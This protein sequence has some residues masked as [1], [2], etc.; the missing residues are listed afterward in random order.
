MPQPPETFDEPALR[1]WLDGLG[2]SAAESVVLAG[3][4]SPRR[5]RRLVRRDASVIVALYP[6]SER[7]AAHRFLRTGA[8]LTA[9]GVRVPAVFAS[10]LARGFVLLEDLGTRTLYEHDH[11]WEERRPWWLRAAEVLVALRAVAAADL[12]ELNPALDAGLLVRELGPA[13]ELILE[14]ALRDAGVRREALAALEAV[15]AAAGAA[16][17]VPCHRDFMARNLVPLANG[18]LAVI[19]HQDLRLGPAAYDWASLLND[20]LFAPPALERELLGRAAALGVDLAAY[21][22]AAVQRGFKAA[23]TFVGFARRGSA[24]HLPLVAPTLARAL[25]HLARLDEGAEVAPAL[26]QA[27]RRADLLQ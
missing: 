2:W 11:G 15:A 25:E 10:D 26:A 23:G 16:P 12:A 27:L 18:E 17:L 20:S 9:R 4:V 5:Y 19:D 1:A 6:A 3:D 22:R 13:R 7:A 8:L 21:R 14:P 24:R